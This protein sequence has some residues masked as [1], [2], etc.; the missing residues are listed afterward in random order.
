MT[1][2]RGC[3]DI[4]QGQVKQI[5]GGSLSNDEA[6]T[7]FVSKYS[8]SHYANLYKQYDIKGCHIIKL[9]PGCDQE[10][11]KA[12]NEWP[13]MLQIGGGIDGTNCQEW[14]EKGASHVILTSY[15]FPD[16][17]FSI[18]RLKEISEKVGRDKL[19]VDLR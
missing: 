10:A 4:H 11:I 3:I 18:E 6:Q 19:V 7:N 9:G 2:F 13:K 17:K 14:I 15:L 5:I 1:K 16:R 12:L 8:S